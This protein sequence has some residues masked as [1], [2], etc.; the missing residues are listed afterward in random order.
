MKELIKLFESG[1]ALCIWRNS[2][3]H[4]MWIETKNTN[5]ELDEKQFQELKELS[6]FDVKSNQN[7]SYGSFIFPSSDKGQP[8]MEAYYLNEPTEKQIN[9][10]KLA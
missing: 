1:G 9:R 7:V 10:V 5:I 6:K 8:I 2:T 4:N 3:P